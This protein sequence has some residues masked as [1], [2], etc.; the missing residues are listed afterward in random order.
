[1]LPMF[2]AQKFAT[3]EGSF[4]GPA[5]KHSTTIEVQTGLL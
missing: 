1:M 5:R 4:G 3:K 2:L